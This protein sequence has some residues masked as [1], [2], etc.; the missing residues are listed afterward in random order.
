MIAKNERCGD[1]L[2]LITRGLAREEGEGLGSNN[3]GL[4]NLNDYLQIV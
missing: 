4:L 2:I 1:H 3:N